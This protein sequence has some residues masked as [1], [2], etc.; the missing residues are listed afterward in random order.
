MASSCPTN[1]FTK[2]IC[3]PQA[4]GTAGFHPS[5]AQD[6][7]NQQLWGKGS[8]ID[9]HLGDSGVQLGGPTHP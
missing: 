6:L 1:Q 8:Q 9:K 4:S 3:G 7:T 2:L 5:S